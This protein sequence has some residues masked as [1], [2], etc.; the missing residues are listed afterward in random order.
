MQK[1]MRIQLR[2]LLVLSALLLTSWL[3]AQIPTIPGSPSSS[4]RIQ[5][6]N[7]WTLSPAG[8]SIPLNSDLPPNMA[9]APDS[10]HLAVTNNGNRP[11][12]ID[13]IKLEK[14]KRAT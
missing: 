4:S 14:R 3:G 13:L 5:L 9:P 7:G 12:Q 8:H 11:Q 10:I 6:P 1:N 2:C